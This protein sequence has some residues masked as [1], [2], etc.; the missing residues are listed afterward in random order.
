M[1]S[2]ATSQ[3]C[4]K[5]ELSNNTYNEEK[6]KR[7]KLG[8]RVLKHQAGRDAGTSVEENGSEELS[9]FQTRRNRGLCRGHF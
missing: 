4:S 5:Q 6:G 1:K 7:I 8:V 3:A 2:A 9:P